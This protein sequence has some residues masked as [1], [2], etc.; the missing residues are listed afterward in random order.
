MNN[1]HIIQ[2]VDKDRWQ[3]AQEFELKFAQQTIKSDDDWNQWWYEKFEQYA[4][5]KGKHFNNILEVGCGP[6][7]NIRYI[8]PE[9]TFNK[10]Y[11]ED[12]LIQYYLTYNLNQPNSFIHYL[13]RKFKEKKIKL[14]CK[15][16]F[17]LEYQ[18]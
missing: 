18:R 2:K 8:L 5:L 6:H 16:I 11:L 9:I 10:L 13:K 12:P 15:G 7:T 17:R 14:S 4:A 1:S 3:Q